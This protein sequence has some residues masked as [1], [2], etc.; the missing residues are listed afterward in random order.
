MQLVKVPHLLCGVKMQIPLP[1]AWNRWYW[2]T[3]VEHPVDPA[4]MPNASNVS[5]TSNIETINA[6][7]N[8]PQL[9]MIRSSNGFKFQLGLS[10]PQTEASVFLISVEET[11]PGRWAIPDS[12]AMVKTAFKLIRGPRD[13]PRTIPP[14]TSEK[15]LSIGA[16]HSMSHNIPQPSHFLA[17]EMTCN[18]SY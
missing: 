14:K 16:M 10:A 18:T 15:A 17:G 13:M 12:Y 8:H 1:G 4:P 3:L 6:C 11:L 9:D 7:G 2:R 5:N